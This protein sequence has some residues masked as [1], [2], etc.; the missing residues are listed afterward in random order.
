MA[1]DPA[2]YAALANTTAASDWQTP[3]DQIPGDQPEQRTSSYR[4]G[5][6]GRLQYINDGA[7]GP[8]KK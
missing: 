6:Q 8:R 7:N 3:S 5:K 4:S 2:E 1:A